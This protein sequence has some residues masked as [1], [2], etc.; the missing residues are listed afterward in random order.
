MVYRQTV[1]SERIRKASRKRILRAARRLFARRGYPATTMRDIADSAG[2]S[3]GNLYFYFRNKD[4]LLGTLFRETRAPIWT[5][6]E[7][8]MSTVPPGA[9]AMAIAMYANILRLLR[10]DRDLMRLFIL[11]GAP[12]AV[13]SQSTNEHME[14]WRT[15]W[16]RHFPGYPRDKMELALSVW[17]GA[18]RRGIDRWV[19]EELTDSPLEVAEFVTRWNLHGAGVAPEEIDRAIE[20]AARAI[21]TFPIKA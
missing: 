7:T 1:R 3:I 19:R 17:T 2:T 13:T 20:T 6:I 18:I 21:K 15:L 8:A 4:E 9:G 12:V 16:L 11:E 14:H 5:W 10:G